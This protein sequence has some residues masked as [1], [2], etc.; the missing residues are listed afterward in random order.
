MTDYIQSSN[1]FCEKIIKDVEEGKES[2]I[3]RAQKSAELKIV[4]DRTEVAKI[5]EK[6]LKDAREKAEL[7]KKKIFSS[8]NLEKK[9]ITLKTRKEII[10][11]VLEETRLKFEEFRNTSDYRNFLKNLVVEGVLGLGENEVVVAIGKQDLHFLQENTLKEI[12][13][14]FAGIG[15]SIKIEVSKRDNMGQGVIVEAKSGR[16]LFDNT[17]SSRIRRLENELRVIIRDV[18]FGE[19]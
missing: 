9:K 18:L 19:Q 16:S 17:I 8:L 10:E 4:S 7:I 3:D 11:K 6:I 1:L 5:K 14:H 13:K 12:T 15:K 2:I